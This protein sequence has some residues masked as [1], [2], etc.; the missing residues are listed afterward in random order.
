MQKTKFQTTD[1]AAAAK[2]IKR[3]KGPL[4]MEVII[5]GHL[6][7]PMLSMVVKSEMAYQMQRYASGYEFTFNVCDNGYNYLHINEKSEW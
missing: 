2:H 7:D 1:A 4:F 6:T 5:G 3:I